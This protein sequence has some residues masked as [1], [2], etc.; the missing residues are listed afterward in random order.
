MSLV[1]QAPSTQRENLARNRKLSIYLEYGKPNSTPQHATEKYPSNE[2]D[3]NDIR[4]RIAIMKA[5]DLATTILAAA[6]MLGGTIASQGGEE[7]LSTQE[8]IQQLLAQDL[9]TRK[10]AFPDVIHAA[11]SKKVIATNPDTPA[12]QRILET[13]S[14]AADE[15]LTELSQKDSKLHQLRRIN[16]AS[17]FF[18][19]LLLKKINA[20][21]HIRCQIPKNTQGKQQRSGYPDLHIIHT[22]TDGTKTHAY[23]DPKLFEKKS[24]ASSLR[25]FY[26]E[27]RTRTNKIQHD[28]IHLLLGICHDGNQG[29]WAFTNWEL[30][31]LSRFSVRLKAEFQA[32]NRDL[33]RK[34][35]IIRSS[36]N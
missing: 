7:E 27:P 16:E 26:Y 31:D 8:I 33:Y 13:I 14:Q 12:H 18:E 9:G 34:N 30:C 22:A 1:N 24:K 17:R 3:E 25:T 19:D 28:A 6:L 21:P 35:L 10:F 15:T 32:S 36:K 20:A 5:N 2:I 11:C 23:L 29:A 4:S